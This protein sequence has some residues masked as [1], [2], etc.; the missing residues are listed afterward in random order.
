MRMILIEPGERRY[1]YIQAPE[2]QEAKLMAGLKGV[3]FGTLTRDLSIVVDEFGLYRDPANGAYF[4]LNGH[5]YSGNAIIFGVGLAGETVPCRDLPWEPLFFGSETQIEAAIATGLVQRPI[6]A[7]NGV[8]VWSWP[9]RDKS[10]LE[11]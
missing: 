10:W 9:S 8:T 7:V 6:A 2:V 4:A 1:S 3:D 5:L 11:R